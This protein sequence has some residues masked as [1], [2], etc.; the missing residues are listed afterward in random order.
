MARVNKIIPIMGSGCGSVG[1]TVAS[2]TR[3]LRFETRHWQNLIYQFIYQFE[4]P[5][6]KKKGQGMAHLFKLTQS[7]MSYIK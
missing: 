5:K 3:D 2:N 7:K 1:R 4:K 6:I